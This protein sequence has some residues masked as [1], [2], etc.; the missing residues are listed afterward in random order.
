MKRLALFVSAV[1]LT[2]SA[3]LVGADPGKDESGKDRNE[4]KSEYRHDRGDDRN[5]KERDDRSGSRGNGRESYFRDRGYTR[6]DIPPGHY[7]PPGECRVW[8]P[9][10]PAGQQPPPGGCRNVPPGAWAIRHPADRPDHVHVVVYEPERPGSVYAV[11]E[12][13]IGSGGLVRVVLDP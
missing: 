6:L 1:V 5:L 10:R 4:G 8:F 7:P 12:F 2:G 11:G 13:E 3:S 9:D